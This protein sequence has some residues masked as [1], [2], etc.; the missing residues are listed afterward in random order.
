[1]LTQHVR[2]QVL[3]VLER[4]PNFTRVLPVQGFVTVPLER[5]PE[6]EELLQDLQ[7]KYKRVTFKWIKPPQSVEKVGEPLASTQLM[8]PPISH[9]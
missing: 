3:D 5:F 4:V 7:E 6:V 1:M 9:L 8:A 2:V